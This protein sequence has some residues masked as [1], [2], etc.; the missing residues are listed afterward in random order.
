MA[1]SHQAPH[2]GLTSLPSELVAR[3]VSLLPSAED[4]ARADG[5]CRLFHETPPPPA[6]P[7]VCE[8]ALRLRAAERGGD[9]ARD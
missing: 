6:P 9:T 4:I 7:S 3:A 2:R 1:T 5:V 8:Q